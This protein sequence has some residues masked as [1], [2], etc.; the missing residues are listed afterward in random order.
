[1]ISRHKSGF[2]STRNAH[3]REFPSHASARNKYATQHMLCDR[4]R[5]QPCATD[6]RAIT[7]VSSTKTPPSRFPLRR[8]APAAEN[9]KEQPTPLLARRPQQHPSQA[10]HHKTQL[11]TPPPTNHKRNYLAHN[12]A[13]SPSGISKLIT[14]SCACFLRSL[15]LRRLS[16]GQWK[17]HLSALRHHPPLNLLSCCPG[18]SHPLRPSGFGRCGCRCRR[19]CRCRYQTCCD[20]A[21]ARGFGRQF[22]TDGPPWRRR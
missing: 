13:C 22:R 18:S 16:D 10:L 2:R 11:T 1:M 6:V 20:T 17:A 5:I 12:Q 3:N 14:R 7:D 19:R 9:S 15:S 8:K 21:R 4:D